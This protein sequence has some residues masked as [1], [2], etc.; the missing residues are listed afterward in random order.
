MLQ[1]VSQ[2]IHKR[3]VFRRLT[4]DC[5]MIHK[6]VDCIGKHD[7]WQSLDDVPPATCV[8][9]FRKCKRVPIDAVPCPVVLRTGGRTPRGHI[10][11][12]NNGGIGGT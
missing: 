3:E 10:S 5:P 12:N 2:R 4:R 9:E 1:A 11:S 8:V 7:T 6:L